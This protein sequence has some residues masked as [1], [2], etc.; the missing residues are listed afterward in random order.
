MS[1]LVYRSWNLPL[2]CNCILAGLVGITAGCSVVEPWAAIICGLLA[3]PVFLGAEHL[4]MKLKVDDPVSAFALHGAVGAYGV[5][6]P[7]FL[8]RL[9]YV[10]QVYPEIADDSNKQGILYGGHGQILLNNFIEVVVIIAWTGG[11]MTIFFLA[12]KFAGV[13]RVAPELEARGLDE[14]HNDATVHGFKSKDKSNK[15]DTSSKG[16]SVHKPTDYSEGPSTNKG[17]VVV[18]AA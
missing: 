12:L 8:A 4:V 1:Q 18:D 13:L 14:F 10:Q 17:S 15:G 16:G 2:V 11:L 3:A 7:G 5:L 9:D 6:F